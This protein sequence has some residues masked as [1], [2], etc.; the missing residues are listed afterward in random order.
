MKGIVSLCVCLFGLG[1]GTVAFAQSAKPAEAR[2]IA[3]ELDRAVAGVEKKSLSLPPKP[4]PKT[5]S[6]LFPPAANLRVCA[7]STNRSSTSQ[8]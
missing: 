5:N 7:P 2:T 4:C 3:G 1:F 8:R 6:R